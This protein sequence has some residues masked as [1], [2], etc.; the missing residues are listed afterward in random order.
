V[1]CSF[2]LLLYYRCVAKFAVYP[3]TLLVDFAARDC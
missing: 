1:F 2:S 3:S